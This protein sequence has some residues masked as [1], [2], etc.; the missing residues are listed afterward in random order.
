MGK[1]VFSGNGFVQYLTEKD[2]ITVPSFSSVD[3]V[4]IINSF[5]RHQEL[6]GAMCIFEEVS[7][8]N[9]ACR[10][11]N[12]LTNIYKLTYHQYVSVSILP[13][14]NIYFT[15]SYCNFRCFVY[16]FRQIKKNKQAFVNVTLLLCYLIIIM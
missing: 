7:I 16:F 15:L 9:T 3:V 12:F 11:C 5:H 13:P 2:K 4:P 14:N 6:V 10:S 1:K 8:Y